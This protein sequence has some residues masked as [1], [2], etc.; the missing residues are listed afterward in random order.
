[1]KTTASV[2]LSVGA[3]GGFCFHFL[4]GQHTHTYIIT[5]SITL[6][7]HTE[8]ETDEDKMDDSGISEDTD[9]CHILMR[10]GTFPEKKIFPS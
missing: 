4:S 2:C 7:I 3:G 10:H 9:A 8:R 6:S 1:M 5:H